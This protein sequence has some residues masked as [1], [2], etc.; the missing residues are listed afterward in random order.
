MKLRLKIIVGLLM[1]T[2]LCLPAFSQSF[3]NGADIT[4]GV[5]SQEQAQAL[6]EFLTGPDDP[7]TPEIEGLNIGRTIF[8]MTRIQNQQPGEPNGIR[9]YKRDRT[10]DG[11]TLLS[12]RGTY[13]PDPDG[14]PHR[15][16]LID[17]D[18]NLIN[19]WP[20]EWAYPANL[21]PNGSVMGGLGAMAELT[22]IPHL[23]QLSWSGEEEWRWSGNPDDVWY[24]EA[25]W[26]SID[27]DE[28]NEP[29]GTPKVS[30]QHHA[31]QREGN[32][33]GY[34]SPGQ[35]AI[36][37]GGKTLILCH[38]IP[39]SESTQHISKSRLYDE[40]IYE[41]DWDGNVL[42]AWYGRES[43]E[44]I[45]YSEEAKQA[46][47]TTRGSSRYP[48][49]ALDYLH[50]NT[51]NYVGPNKWYDQGDLRFHPENIVTD[52]RTS[53][54]MAII[55]RHD[56]PD[57][58]W[59]AGDIIWKVG[60]NYNN[61]TADDPSG[62]LGQIIGMHHAHMIQKGL[63]GAGNILV[64]DNG[65]G[66]GYG[67]LIE[68]LP[69]RSG[70]TYRNY[71]RV[72]EFNPIT[73]EMVWEYKQPKP[74]ADYDGDGV[75]LGNDR[76]LFSYFIC[77]AQRLENGNT[78]ITEG[79]TG[80]LIEVTQENEVVWEYYSDFGFGFNGSVYRAYRYPYSWIPEGMGN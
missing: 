32:P 77:S 76:K 69:P 70:N 8:G 72:I 48:E 63:P 47:M 11:C 28:P 1:A 22:G 61:Y 45:G 7:C 13:R 55:A 6:N 64:F 74:T 31:H 18:G 34:Y 26:T 50:L 23:V 33:V 25:E 20:I 51:A 67:A 60:P 24:T 75:I 5:L 52:S 65:G 19:S 39:A 58:A 9:I 36:P 27:P 46:I 56:H 80:R 73:F 78:L 54:F 35:E 3:W 4:D 49:P 62:R 21:L 16:V 14:P 41:V 71:S 68:G 79:Q 15:A 2:F 44:Q 57:G 43:F 29:I 38:H 59:S 30:G 17:M 40:A 66:A 53:N 12:L 42:F 37:Y 10:W